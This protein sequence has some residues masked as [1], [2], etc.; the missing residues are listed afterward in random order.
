MPAQK[1]NDS[2]YDRLMNQAHLTLQEVQRRIQSRE[3]ELT[4]LHQQEQKLQSFIGQRAKESAPDGG[5]RGRID[6]RAVLSKLP[7]QFTAADVK[8]VR[9]LAQK[10]SS[11][12]FAAITR[13]IDA[14]LV[15]RKERG[16]Y[17]RIG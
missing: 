15:K 17:E 1:L 9:G 16:V 3:T 2:G 10:K 8:K 6:W 12:V 7:K 4:T 5:S 13:W 14:K 11:E